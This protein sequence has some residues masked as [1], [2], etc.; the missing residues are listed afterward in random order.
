MLRCLCLHG[1]RQTAELFAHQLHALEVALSSAS[2]A[3]D[4]INAPYVLPKLFEED[5]VETRSW[6]NPSVDSEEAYHLGDALL[7][8][9]LRET[10]YHFLL[11]FSQGGVMIARCAARHGGFIPTG[12][13]EGGGH[14]SGLIFIASPNIAHHV[15]EAAVED[16]P[17]T[18]SSAVERYVVSHQGK[19]FLPSSV[20]S[21]HVMGEKDKIVPLAE[22]HAF[23]EWCGEA[24][25]E[26]IH[27]HAHSV[28]R[29]R[30]I[31]KAMKDFF[32]RIAPSCT[33]VPKEKEDEKVMGEATASTQPVWSREAL[34]GWKEHREAE[35]EMLESMFG[36]ETVSRSAASEGNHECGAS[37]AAVVRLPLFDEEL[38][39]AGIDSVLRRWLSQL[40]VELHL[41]PQY[42][43]VLPSAIKIIV[44]TLAAGG[45]EQ[46]PLSSR[47]PY[48]VEV[49]KWISL[50]EQELNR[51]ARDEVEGSTEEM[52]LPLMLFAR[53]LGGENM[54]QLA[55]ALENEKNG[56]RNG[57]TTELNECLEAEKAAR[58]AAASLEEEEL[59][60]DIRLERALRAD[61]E[62]LAL[63][64]E[65]SE[66]DRATSF[67]AWSPVLPF[68][69][70]AIREAGYGATQSAGSTGAS[71]SSSCRS[72]KVKIG[73]IGKPSAGKSTFFNAITDPESESEAAK[74]AAF[75]FT[76]IE[77][78]NGT[79]YAP[80]VC[81]CS[82]RQPL[83]PCTAL[84]GHVN[85]LGKPLAARRHPIM[86]KDV[87]GLVKGAYKGRG[88]G[89]QFLNDLCDSDVLVH[90]VDGAGATNEDGSACKAGEGSA[91]EDIEWV[92]AEVHFWVYDNL[93][94][95]WPS[96]VRQPQ[97]LR[98]MFSGYG[99]A[100]A[101]VDA[102]LRRLGVHVGVTGVASKRPAE[103]VSKAPPAVYPHG[104]MQSA[105]GST[106][107]L[108]EAVR[109]WGWKEL[110]RLVAV[111]L[112]LRFPIVVALNKS[113]LSSAPAL[114]AQLCAKYPFERF[115]PMSAKIEW[116]LLNLR[117]QHRVRYVSGG[118]DF[119]WIDDTEAKEAYAPLQRF[120]ELIRTN[121][122][123]SSSP[124]NQPP[125]VS[126]A[127]TLT[128]S[129]GVQ[130]VLAAALGAC[131]M[132]IV[133]PVSEFSSFFTDSA[134]AWAL[135]N[136]FCF[137]CGV[138]AEGVFSNL[139]QKGLA[140]GKL[141]RFEV[142]PVECVAQFHQRRISSAS[143][144]VW[145]EAEV[146]KAVAE[147]ARVLRR[148]DALPLGPVLL[149]VLTNKR[150]SG[151]LKG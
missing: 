84:H 48:C 62:A 140:E 67:T 114:H 119:E 6:R 138:S 123:S 44:R 97:R 72:W 130:N 7:D 129:T 79:G 39:E 56:V 137:R 86:I 149:R 101:F 13:A 58:E 134:S 61:R 109:S 5:A 120:F 2:I 19:A 9:K 113:D 4:Y 88:N 36:E 68:L 41:S 94:K 74:V 83:I 66:A 26:L 20:P 93:S 132:S 150:Q 142:L 89:S 77:P 102:V 118:D 8:A 47:F 25:E 17:A 63:L 99:S 37:I 69:H 29:V 147:H 10:T 40:Y 21:L 82:S 76:T 70:E 91:V 46:A 143:E 59:E 104:S 24:G 128:R 57:R 51:Y 127:L 125:P 85:V 81:P 38:W 28:P 78:N 32:L 1:S 34:A 148:T 96:I 60:M 54:S 124:P 53:Q 98:T 64:Q 30:E 116:D 115:V 92:R 52:L 117:R 105:D 111:Y 126:A 144:H 49:L 27:H 131:P 42:P 80:L 65:T 35:L 135:S 22:S 3:F 103:R 23:K 90:V 95:K 108:E 12:P 133:Y 136:C 71:T 87:A 112:R 107:E 139:E 18:V 141:V 16:L 33:A 55:H 110:H 14:V 15:P 145:E 121:T 50:A 31:E 75:P 151:A 43:A 146:A 11:G 100:P 45:E 106:V 122:H 73:L